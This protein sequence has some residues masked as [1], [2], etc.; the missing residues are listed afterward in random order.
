[1][2]EVATF[3]PEHFKSR[4]LDYSLLNDIQIYYL[5]LWSY[6]NLSV[7]DGTKPLTLDPT[8]LSHKY[9]SKRGRNEYN[10]VNDFVIL[11]M[12]DM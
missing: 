8:R 3:I 12:Q 10:V 5:T 11:G 6:E 4:S 7:Y 2:I 1:M 9:S